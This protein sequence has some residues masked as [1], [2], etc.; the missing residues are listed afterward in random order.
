VEVGTDLGSS[1]SSGSS[2]VEP[3]VSTGSGSSTGSGASGGGSCNPC[4]AN[5][6]CLG[7]TCPC[8][9]GFADDGAGHCQAVDPGD[10]ASRSQAEVCSAWQAGHQTVASSPFTPGANTCDPGSLPPEAVV[11]A[12]RRLNLFRWLVGLGPTTDDPT[13]DPNDQACADI[14]ANNPAGPQAHFPDPSSTCYSSAGA[15]GAGSS[16]IAW[17]CD[18]AADA[19]DQWMED[20]GNETTLGHRRWLLNPPLGPVGLGFYSG[21]SGTWGSASCLGVF[22]ASNPG[23]NPSWYAYPPPGYAPLETVS[24]IWSLHSGQWGVDAITVTITRASDG[25]TLPVQMLPLSGGYGQDAAAWQLD[26]SSGQG[27]TAGETYHVTIS[28]LSGAPDFTYDVM[29]VQ[30]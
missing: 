2:G 8:D 30:C 1:G 21:G 9:P 16:N 12:L 17:G 24:G 20:D 11:D 18:S 29:P 19:M 10:P 6:H 14:S 15:A 28:H 22:G 27:F 25:A 23:P 26:P 3:F 4:R 13:Q 5:A 7:G